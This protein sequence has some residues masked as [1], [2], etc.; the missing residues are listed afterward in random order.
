MQASPDTVVATN[1]SACTTFV[2]CVGSLVVVLVLLSEA[3]ILSWPHGRCLSW[4]D[5]PAVEGSGRALQS[6]G[7]LRDILLRAAGTCKQVRISC[8][9]HTQHARPKILSWCQHDDMF[10]S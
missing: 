6:T 9:V 10:L 2:L 1:W 7:S 4:I 8:N 3:I 5:I